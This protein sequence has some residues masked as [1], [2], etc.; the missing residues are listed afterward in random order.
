MS[1]GRAGLIPIAL[2]LGLAGCKPAAPPPP[3]DESGAAAEAIRAADVAWDKAFSAK[4]TAAAVAAVEAMGSVLAPGT[5]I[6]TGPEAIRTVFTGFWSLPN[7]TLHWTP[8]KVEAGRSGDLGYS[9][10]TYELTFNDPK[11]KPMTDHGKYVTVWRKQAD[12]SWKVVADVFNSDLPAPG[13]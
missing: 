13:S 5:P 4:D 10:G 6:A 7:M 12:G 1:T 3:A 9:M 11:G 2:A 8:T